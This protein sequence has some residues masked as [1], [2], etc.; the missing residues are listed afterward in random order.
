MT[1]FW[2]RAA[3]TAWAA[4]ISPQTSIGSARY[5]IDEAGRHDFDSSNSAADAYVDLRFEMDTL[6]LL[7]TCPHP[8]NPAAAI[9]ASARPRTAAQGARVRPMTTYA[10]MHA[11]GEYARIREHGTLP[12]VRLRRGG[13]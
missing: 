4:V 13:A 1:L 5:P 6:V 3:N 8:L 7:H 2:W 9:S 12:A 10:A 11:S